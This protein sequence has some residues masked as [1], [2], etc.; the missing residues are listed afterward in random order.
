MANTENKGEQT[1]ASKLWDRIKDIPIDIFALPNQTV[2]DYARREEGM[3][4]IFPNDVFLTLRAAAV[5]PALE[6]ALGNAQ[7]RNMVKLAKNEK[8]EVSQQNKY[9]VVKVVPKD[10]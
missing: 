9:V 2:K 1:G 4:N 10:L 5:Y 6:E 7:A 8:F 3:D